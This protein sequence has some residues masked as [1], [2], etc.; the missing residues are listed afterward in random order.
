M[1]N[2]IDS[3]VHFI[4]H[5]G[6]SYYGYNMK[7][8]SS[9]VYSLSNDK[10]CF[11]YSQGCMAGGFDD[12]WGDDCFAEYFT[13]KT[14]TGAFAGIWNA[15]YGWFWSYSTD[16][17][18]QRFHREY[19]D[20]VFG[21]EIPQ[22]GRANADSKE[23]NLPIIGRSCIR[24]V[25]YQTNLF[26]DPSLK[27]YETGQQN[28]PPETP[29]IDGPK[30]GTIGIEYNYEFTTIDPDD[31]YLYIMV[32]WDDGTPVDWDGPYGP[33]NLV[34]LSH[35]WDE[36]GSYQIQA[37][38]KD[39]AGEESD[40]GSISVFIPKNKAVYNLLLSRFIN[41]FPLIKEVVLRLLKL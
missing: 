34:T 31:D 18:S 13:V 12:P 19:W 16:G 7:M 14:D 22:L 27:F 17:D 29:E 24:W 3:G 10:Y 32:D 25:Y 11:I 8:D 21:E 6:H 39:P 30:T 36:K 35:T 23:D 20:A 38:L 28:L 9:D 41:H 33:G 37:K 4:N 40:W 5:L 15:R 2:L 1:M 26:G